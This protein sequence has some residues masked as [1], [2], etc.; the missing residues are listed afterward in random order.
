MRGR[1][2][3]FEEIRDYR[4]GRR[5]PLDRLEGDGA[6]AEAACARLQRGARPRRRCW[7]S[8]SGCRCSSAAGLNMKSVTAAEA[9]AIARLAHPRRRRP[10]R[11]DHVQRSRAWSSSG[12][13]AAAAPCCKSSPAIVAQN[14]ALGVGRGIASS[15][16]MLNRALEQ[17]QRRAL[18]DAAVIIIS[19]FDG[20]DDATR[21]VSAPWRSTTMWLRCWSMIPMQSDLPASARLTVTDGELQID[22]RGRPRYGAAAH[23]GR[24][25]GAAARRVRLDH[26]SRRPGAAAQRRRR[27]RAT[28]APPARPLAGARRAAWQAMRTW[29]PALA[30]TQPVPVDPVAGLI[31]IP[32][33]PPVSLWPQTW[34]SRIAIV[35]AVG[36]LVAA[37]WWYVHRR[38]ANRYRRAALGELD[39]IAQSSRID[40]AARDR[41]RARAAGP[42]HGAC[43]VSAR[44]DRAA[45]GSGMARVS[46][47]ELRR[48]RLLARAGRRCTPRPTTIAMSPGP[49]L[50][51]LTRPRSSLDQG[52]P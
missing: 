47:P 32:L 43:G 13:G 48:A 29:R 25:A 2:L 4:P 6:A 31:D 34:T 28:V 24:D 11:G 44:A 38:R 9:A 36:G 17:A 37:A 33:P 51:A 5:R 22:A 35:V 50:R 30:D 18:H 8:T 3:N 20:A 21:R 14:R 23:H 40:A 16:A 10:R 45:H 52:A 19:D 41:D 7:S 12:R 46:R 49:R 15:P 1:G 26:R 39:R 27:D 42:P